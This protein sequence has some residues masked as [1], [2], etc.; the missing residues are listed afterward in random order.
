M[1]EHYGLAIPEMT[2]A[3]H[4]DLRLAGPSRSQ[5]HLGGDI[6]I[7]GWTLLTLKVFILNVSI[8]VRQTNLSTFR[9]WPTMELG[10]AHRKLIRNSTLT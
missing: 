8:G 6:E 10:I 3:C 4:T 2:I 5:H 1:N 7:A 9:Y